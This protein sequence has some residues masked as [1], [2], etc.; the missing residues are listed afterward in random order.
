VTN[1]LC[2]LIR[3][4]AIGVGEVV[5]AGVAYDVYAIR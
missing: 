4:Q 1:L 2:A 5:P 3:I